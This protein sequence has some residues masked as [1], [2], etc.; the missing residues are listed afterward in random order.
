MVVFF[1]MFM[2]ELKQLGDTEVGSDMWDRDGKW[3][4]YFTTTIKAT[5]G[6]MDIISMVDVQGDYKNKSEE[7]W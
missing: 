3:K 2:I 7:N 5:N 6:S 1:S 4:N